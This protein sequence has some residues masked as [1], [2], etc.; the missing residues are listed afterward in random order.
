MKK[1]HK[2]SLILQVEEHLN[3]YSNIISIIPTIYYVVNRPSTPSP[4]A[5][6]DSLYIA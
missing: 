4:L 6:I 1:K 2:V 3:Q 5:Y